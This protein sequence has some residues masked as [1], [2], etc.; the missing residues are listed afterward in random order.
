LRYRY[1]ERGNLR[2]AA[3]VAAQMA[4]DQLPLTAAGAAGVPQLVYLKW[5][6]PCH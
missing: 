2:A 3:G 6:P 1:A 4:R 5:R